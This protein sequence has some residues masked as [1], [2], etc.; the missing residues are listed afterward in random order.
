[1]RRVE[2]LQFE[3]RVCDPV[4][5]GE[6]VWSGCASKQEH[7]LKRLNQS[8]VDAFSYSLLTVLRPVLTV[9]FNF[10]GLQCNVHYIETISQLK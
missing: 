6:G 10:G 3:P 4:H 1:M 2:A 7:H 8:P 5:D 9:A